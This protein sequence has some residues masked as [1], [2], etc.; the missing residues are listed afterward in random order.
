MDGILKADYGD[1][2]QREANLKPADRARA[3]QI[4]ANFKARRASMGPREVRNEVLALG[5]AR[6]QEVV[7]HLQSG[8][9]ALSA[10]AHATTEQLAGALLGQQVPRCAHA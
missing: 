7:E 9:C 3:Q 5:P 6:T 2:N 10:A 8:A 1:R 4:E